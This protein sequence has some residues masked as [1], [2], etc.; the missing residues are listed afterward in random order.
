MSSVTLDGG[1]NGDGSGGNTSG[2]KLLR[3]CLVWD[4]EGGAD[5]STETDD[6]MPI[7]VGFSLDEGR[8]KAGAEL[9]AIASPT[10]SCAA[11]DEEP[12]LEGR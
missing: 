9:E 11:S 2:D 10:R 4:V 1:D 7:R 12:P 6:L 5:D 8:M 3:M